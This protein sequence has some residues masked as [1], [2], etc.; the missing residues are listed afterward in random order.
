MIVIYGFGGFESTVVASACWSYFLNKLSIV[1]S[2]C[3][4]W[5]LLEMGNE[6]NALWREGSKLHF[7]RWTFY[8]FFYMPTT[9][10]RTSQQNLQCS[11]G[12][13]DSERTVSVPMAGCIRDTWLIGLSRPLTWRW[14]QSGDGTKVSKWHDLFGG[15]FGGIFWGKQIARYA[16]IMWNNEL[17][18]KKM[19]YVHQPTFTSRFFV[20]SFFFNLFFCSPH[21]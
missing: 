16:K 11:T 10:P 13:S 3:Y 6:L 18:G 12:I 2:R 5:L 9:K 19:T 8:V 17:T 4:C 14:W 21:S 15:G 7:Q 20:S 1:W